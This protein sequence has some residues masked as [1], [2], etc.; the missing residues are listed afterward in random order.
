MITIFVV[1][2]IGTAIVCY[3]SGYD[4]AEKVGNT[5]LV[6]W[7]KQ[8]TELF[9]KE[10]AAAELAAFNDGHKQGVREAT[11]KHDPKTGRFAK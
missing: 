8:A 10:K 9:L 4:R 3:F 7:Q 11:P 6:E 5:R 2:L 1:I